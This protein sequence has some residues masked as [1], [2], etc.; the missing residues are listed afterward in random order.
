MSYGDALRK[1]VKIDDIETLRDIYDV[2]FSDRTDLLRFLRSSELWKLNQRRNLI[3]HRRS[4]VDETYIENTGDNLRV[5][6]EL[7]IAPEQLE[8][9]GERCVARFGGWLRDVARIADD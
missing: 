4:I 6:S 1:I 2:L 5:G 8:A 3:L 7:A 9:I